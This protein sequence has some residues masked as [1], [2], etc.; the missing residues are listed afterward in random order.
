MPLSAEDRA[1]LAKTFQEA[2]PTIE[3]VFRAYAQKAGA[4]ERFHIG[5]YDASD[6]GPDYAKAGDPAARAIAE[7]Q[8]RTADW[9]DRNFT[10]NA[11]RKVGASLRTGRDTGDLARNARE[12]FIEGDMTSPGGCLAEIDGKPVAIGTSGL[13]GTEDEPFALL[14]IEL[15]KRLTPAPEGQQGGPPR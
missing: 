6:A 15:M 2:M 8:I 3:E 11:R 1:A 13:R 10:D 12:L 7:H 14:V 5:I 4:P 9:G